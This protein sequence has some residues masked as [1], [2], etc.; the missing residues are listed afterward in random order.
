MAMA[1]RRLLHTA[2][3][4]LADFEN[5]GGP[6]PSYAILSHRWRKEITFEQFRKAG[7]DASLRQLNIDPSF[8]ASRDKLM[9]TCNIAQKSGVDYVWAD[10]I[11]IDKAN[12]EEPVSY[13]H[14]TLPTKRIV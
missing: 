4:Q 2:T 14:L 3:L 12:S 9:N 5:Y 8:Q 7:D 11:C 6:M 10:T 1:P 13:T